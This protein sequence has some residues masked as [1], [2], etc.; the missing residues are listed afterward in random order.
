MNSKNILLVV[1]IIAAV[2]AFSAFLASYSRYERITGYASSTGMVNL[3]VEANIGLNFTTNRIAWGSGRVTEGL[4]YAYLDTAMRNAT[5][6]VNG[7]WTANNA[8]LMAENIGN[9][10]L[11]VKFSTWKN[12]TVL[13]G[14]VA[15]TP[16]Y[17]Y[18]V[19]NNLT[20]SC[21]GAVNAG[22]SYGNWF[23]VNS[24][25]N[26]SLVDGT[27]ICGNLT[28]YNTSN[29]IRMDIRLTIPRDAKTGA[30]G[31][32]IILTYNTAA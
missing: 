18:N 27:Q 4:D 25:G 21:S 26:A 3:T 8:G 14:G 30:L 16:A 19:T 20:G 23:D 24:S 5:A 1:A 9:S 7:N 32:S 22:F 13:L 6:V 10:N 28:P 2:V 17:Q 29:I 12:A 15:V 11:T 31:D